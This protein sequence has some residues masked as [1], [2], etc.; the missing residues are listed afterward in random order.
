[1]TMPLKKS[2]LWVWNAIFC[3]YCFSAIEMQASSVKDELNENHS[4]ERATQLVQA[5]PPKD[6]ISEDGLD[7]PDVPRSPDSP[8]APDSPIHIDSES[9][10]S[11]ESAALCLEETFEIYQEMTFSSN[12]P[13][14]ALGE[15]LYLEGVSDWASYESVVEYS[16]QRSPQYREMTGANIIEKIMTSYEEEEAMRHKIIRVLQKE[17]EDAEQKLVGVL[18]L[19]RFLDDPTSILINDF[20]VDENMRPFKSY[21]LGKLFELYSSELKGSLYYLHSLNF[22]NVD[23]DAWNDEFKTLHDNG[24]QEQEVYI[25]LEEDKSTCIEPTEFYE[26]Y[27][28]LYK[29][30]KVHAF[31]FVRF[32]L[33]VREKSHSAQV[34]G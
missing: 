28:A 14:V 19:S 32:P 4:F 9:S 26:N 7:S 8:H 21:I 15:G 5:F 33:D 10:S 12:F 22:N 34:S 3:I 16:Y 18:F 30:K 20:D 25:E 31:T 29:G 23:K 11:D 27:A 24:F 2:M 1:M 6:L 17:S 13:H